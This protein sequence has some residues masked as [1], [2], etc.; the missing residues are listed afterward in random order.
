VAW[1]VSVAKWRDIPRPLWGIIIPAL[2]FDT[3]F[4]GW[5]ADLMHL[6]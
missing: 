6:L 2:V 4:V 3:W 5:W 1:I